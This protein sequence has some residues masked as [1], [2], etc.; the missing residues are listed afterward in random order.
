MIKCHPG[1]TKRGQVSSQ[2]YKYVHAGALS[3]S[4]INAN[5]TSEL[6]LGSSSLKLSS[7]LKESVDSCL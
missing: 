1:W 3:L 5:N 4:Y 6:A 2:N 7:F